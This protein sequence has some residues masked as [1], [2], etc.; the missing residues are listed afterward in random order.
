MS[1]TR[2]LF[3]L[4]K[5]PDNLFN[6]YSRVNLSDFKTGIYTIQTHVAVSMLLSFLI[7]LGKALSLI[8]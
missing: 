5:S 1:A 6:S 2:L 7:L 8:K 4:L 3:I